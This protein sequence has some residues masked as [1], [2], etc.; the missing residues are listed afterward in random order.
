MI[1]K[2]SKK[3]LYFVSSERFLLGIAGGLF[4]PL[5]PIVALDL[6]VG[7]D[8]LGI[9]ISLSTIGLLFMALSIG[10][11]LDL[12]GFKKVIFIG[13]ALS[14][15]GS[16]GLF[17]SRSYQLFT[18]SYF[19][20]NIGGMGI[21]NISTMVLTGSYYFDSRSKNLM[22]INIIMCFGSIVAPLLVSLILKLNVGWQFLYLFMA[23]PQIAIGIWFFFI[24]IPEHIKTRKS[25]VTILKDHRSI[26]GTPLFLLYCF[27]VL[28][29]ESIMSTF[30]TWFTTY[31]SGLHIELF[32]SSIFLSLYVI[33]LM[34][35]MIIKNYL[36]GLIEERKLLVYSIFLSLVFFILI[37]FTGNLIAKIVFICLFGICICG[38]F[39][40]IYSLSLDIGLKY[41]NTASGIIYAFSY[42]GT[43]IFQYLSGYLSE[44]FS[45][46]SVL[47]IDA[48]LIFALLAMSL[49]IYR[50]SRVSVHF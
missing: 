46:N 3:I 21:I 22:R 2:K 29:Y 48:I 24:R 13:L 5:I 16:V 9:A 47:Y 10:N 45:K 23:A 4:A 43:I 19:I 30:S 26:I 7:L 20:L 31:F 33:S 15:I 34:I 32:L 1:E 50:K 35:G 18:I 38:I 6:K 12:L 28:I 42:L 25:I 41:T 14:V 36:L 37:I 11:L 17:F 44:H 40:I 8:Y 39:S 27:I 49:I